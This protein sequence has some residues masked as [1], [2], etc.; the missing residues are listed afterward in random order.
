VNDGVKIWLTILLVL[1]VVILSIAGLGSL[2]WTFAIVNSIGPAGRL[3][4][5]GQF[6]LLALFAFGFLRLRSRI[7]V[8]EGRLDA[9]FGGEAIDAENESDEPVA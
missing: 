6:I 2:L 5:G 7:G 8:L 9:A 4:F 1:V 3:L